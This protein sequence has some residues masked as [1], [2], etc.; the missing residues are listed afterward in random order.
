MH[1]K[2]FSQHRFVRLCEDAYLILRRK[3]ALFINLLAMMLQTGIPE[4]RSIDD[5]NYVRSVG[6]LSYHILSANWVTIFIQILAAINF[7]L[8]GVWR[9]IED[10]FY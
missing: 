1:Y 4:L 5:L 7:S 9:L 10:S 3:A 8:G 6:Q 2:S